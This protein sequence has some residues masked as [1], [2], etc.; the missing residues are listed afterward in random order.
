MAAPEKIGKGAGL[1][2]TALSR[3]TSPPSSDTTCAATNRQLGHVIIPGSHDAGMGVWTHSWLGV[4]ANTQTQALNFYEQLVARARYFDL[5]VVKYRDN[6]QEYLAAHVSDKLSGNVMGG[7]GESVQSILHGINRSY[8]ET[9]GE[10]I[11]LWVRYLNRLPNT[12]VGHKADTRLMNISFDN[13]KLITD[14]G[15]SASPSI[16]RRNMS[17]FMDSVIPQSDRVN[18]YQRWF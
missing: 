8:K 10:A 16:E 3:L 17:E 14:V 1:V 13:F 7:G 2:K 12:L 15:W 9:P 4:P 11:I 6:N 18:G 5:R